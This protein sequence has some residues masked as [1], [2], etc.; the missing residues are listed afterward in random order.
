MS[1]T[2]DWNDYRHFLAVATTGSLSGAARQLGVSQPT[3]GRRIEAL[4]QALHVRL[5]DRLSR[6][7]A[8]TPSGQAIVAF[9]EGIE[10][11]A[12][13]IEAR[14]AGFDAS[15]SGTVVLST[16]DALAAYWLV[17]RMHILKTR[18]PQLTVEIR[19]GL[20]LS[21]LQRR[22]SDIALRMGG[23]GSDDL[24]GRQL[25]YVSFGLYAN[26][27]YVHDFGMPMHLDELRDHCVIESCASSAD[28]IQN[29]L[30]QETTR[31]AEPTLICESTIA[32][33]AAVQAGL[34][35]GALP[36]YAG[37]VVDE[38]CRVLPESFEPR[39]ELWLLTHQ[40]LRNTAR[41]RAVMDFVRE[42][43]EASQSDV[44]GEFLFDQ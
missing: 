44:R 36:N 25:G 24:I 2:I 1:R 23:P 32:Q 37:G 3:V 41:I 11:A 34:G 28:L 12:H 40:E 7:Y 33:I 26:Q 30:L 15:L 38:L 31:G 27:R 35:I 43:V 14:V 22:E 4:E 29:R 9:A 16:T 19:T 10:R 17:P 5:F 20:S 21:D 8:L 39:I 18:H 6:G 42:E 13:N